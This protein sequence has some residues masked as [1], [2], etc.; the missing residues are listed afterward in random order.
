MLLLLFVVL[1]FILFILVAG[2]ES[3]NIVEVRRRYHILCE[4]CEKWPKKFHC[5]KKRIV[6][7]FFKKG[8][9]SSN[10]GYNINKGEEIGICLDG[11]PN[12]MFHVLLHELA[13]STVTVYSHSKEFWENFKELCGY[14]KDIGIYE[15]TEYKKFCG[16]VIKD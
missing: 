6:I 12:D 4:T 10:I 13:H 1:F 16:K 8:I 7:A 2:R 5:L 9:L 15:K 11:T 3:P 14:C